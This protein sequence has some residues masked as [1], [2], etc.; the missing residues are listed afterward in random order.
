MTFLGLYLI[1]QDSNDDYDTF[2][3]AVVVAESEGKAGM[4]HPLGGKNDKDD[5]ESMDTWAPPDKV[6]VKP[7]GLAAEG[8]K[9]GEVIC[10]SFNAG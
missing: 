7:L 3:S 4:I 9:A 5:I 10:S 2:D 6:Y 1:W 8:L